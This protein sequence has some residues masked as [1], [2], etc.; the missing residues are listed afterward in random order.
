VTAPR[1]LGSTRARVAVVGDALLDRDVE[2][3]VERLSPD[4]PVPVVDGVQD[5]ARPGGAGLAA[6]LAAADG[7]AVTLVT[8]LGR[9]PAGVELRCLLDA[10]GVEVVDLGLAAPTPE[11]V[12]VLAAGRPLVRIDRGE[13]RAAT[14]GAATAEPR[15]AI[16]SADAVLVSDY[17]RGVA[18]EP[19]IR[20]VLESAARER[21]LVWDPHPAGP[22]PVPGAAL[23][24]PNA[25]EAER[26]APGGGAGAAAVA[27][28]ARTL[29]R[30]WRSR[31]VCVTLGTGGALLVGRSAHPL[32]VPA[33]AVRGGDP[34]GAGDR[35]ASRVAGELAG[36]AAI[37]DA[38]ERAVGAASGFVDAGGA[39][40][41]RLGEP[42]A[43]AV[44]GAGPR[45]LD[46]GAV[47]RAARERA[48]GRRV[49]ATAGCFDLLHAGHVRMLQA[50]RGLGD[51]LVVC[52]N[53]DRSVSALKGPGRPIV[54]QAARAAVLEALESVDAVLAFDE[55]TPVAV[56]ERL[57]P[58][59]YVKGGDYSEDELPE[60]ATVTA[61]GG[62]VVVLP[63]LRGHSTSRLIAEA[64]ERGAA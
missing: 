52:L 13:R 16:A 53:S 64:V 34:C 1:E 6:A 12:R 20:R 55:P 15:S 28:R 40:S 3:K 47:E 10:A 7:H 35:F 48:A 58:D 42:A 44:G 32:L 54:P 21:P 26:L 14:V 31:A 45:S 23:A 29:L 43:R 38:V 49:V 46:G 63:Y 41:V 2:G 18:A 37:A 8:A 19:G 60:A 25:A 56:L 27:G 39:A 5:R 30:R 51:C 57:R 22:E 62:Q 11:K 59:V 4:A 24:T 61:L 50:A 36:G 9:D 17:G 33:P